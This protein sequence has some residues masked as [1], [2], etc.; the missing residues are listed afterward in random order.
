MDGN[1]LLL[2]VGL[3]IIVFVAYRFGKGVA[4]DEI[5]TIYGSKGDH[6][7]TFKRNG[8]TYYVLN[9]NEYQYYREILEKIRAQ[10]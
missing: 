6:S 5:F 8:E 7:G 9:Y 2:L 4:Y 10:D 3:A 1:G